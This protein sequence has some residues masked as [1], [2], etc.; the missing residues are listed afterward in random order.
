MNFNNAEAGLKRKITD[1]PKIETELK[2]AIKDINASV[3]SAGTIDYQSSCANC[4][5]EVGAPPKKLKTHSLYS[6]DNDKNIE[7]SVLSEKEVNSIFKELA[8]RSDIPFGYPMD[9]CYAR[10]HKMT[11]ILDEKGIISGKAFVEGELYVDS[12]TFGEIGWGYHVAPV[13]LV[14]QNSAIIPYVIDPSLFTKPV[15]QTE[16]K[17]K[18]LEKSKAILSREYFTKRFAYDPNDRES[19]LDEYPEETV[20]SMTETNQ[21]YSDLLKRFKE[22]LKNNKTK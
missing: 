10:A 9:G 3:N 5:K 14:K 2:T 16:W 15:P 17:A 18:M 4:P 6:K 21:N 7:L 13:V 20:L 11:T 22:R 12:E 8:S 19:D 1:S